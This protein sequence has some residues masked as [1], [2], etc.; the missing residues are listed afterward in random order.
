ME[1]KEHDHGEEFFSSLFLD[2]NDMNVCKEPNVQ[3]I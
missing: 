3:W 1:K 2:A